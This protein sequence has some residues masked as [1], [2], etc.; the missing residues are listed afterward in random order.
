MTVIP[1]LS[2][3]VCEALSCERYSDADTAPSEW[4]PARVIPIVSAEWIPA[5]VIPM[6]ILPPQS[7]ALRGLFRYRLAGKSSP[8]F[9][10]LPSQRVWECGKLSTISAL[11][12]W[13]GI[14]W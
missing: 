9:A 12:R 2:N 8:S 4:G 3:Q 6:L 1:I 10:V 5:R 14:I 13:V 11:V 7:E